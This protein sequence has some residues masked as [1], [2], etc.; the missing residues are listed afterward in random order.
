[1]STKNETPPQRST[2]NHGNHHNLNTHTQHHRESCVIG[3]TIA[4]AWHYR[5]CNT[6]E[7]NDDKNV[8]HINTIRSIFKT[9]TNNT[10]DLH[11][12]HQPTKS[13][14]TLDMIENAT[15]IMDIGINI[16]ENTYT[17]TTTYYVCVHSTKTLNMK[18]LNP[19]ES[20]QGKLPHNISYYLD[21]FRG[22]PTKLL[23][24]I[25]NEEP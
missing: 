17:T 9:I 10:T 1:M 4:T 22:H 20:I 15:N 7:N 25:I 3:S 23:G 13:T 18:L 14:L 11:I 8:N 6:H 19:L 2:D 24:I 21:D 5:F 12:R 16:T